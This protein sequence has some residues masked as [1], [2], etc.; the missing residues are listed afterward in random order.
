MDPVARVMREAGITAKT[1]R[2]F[3]P[4]TDAT[5]SYPVAENV[6]VRD[7]DPD[8]PTKSWVAEV[9]YMA[10]HE[11]RLYSAVVEDLFSR[12]VVGWPPSSS[13]GPN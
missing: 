3:R 1:K 11:G 6:L 13:R 10:T 4:T 9:S 5:H 8:Q 2:K 7:F 12:R